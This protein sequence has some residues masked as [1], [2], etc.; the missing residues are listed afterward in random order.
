[1]KF[2]LLIKTVKVTNPRNCLVQI[3]GV[4]MADWKAERLEVHYDA[5]RKEVIIRPVQTLQA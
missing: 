1:M 5:D 2:N 3:P 4:V